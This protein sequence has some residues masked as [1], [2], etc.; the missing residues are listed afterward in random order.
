MYPNIQGSSQ[1]PGGSENRAW[2]PHNSNGSESYQRAVPVKNPVSSIWELSTAWCEAQVVAI[3]TS[4]VTA[5]ISRI[6]LAPS[7]QEILAISASSLH[8]EV[9]QMGLTGE[10]GSCVCTLTSKRLP[11]EAY[12]RW[13]TPQ[14]RVFSVPGQP[15]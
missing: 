12:T 15:E 9:S 8:V 10:L 1:F 6:P 7:P 4:T 13:G 5:F 2:R 14:G 3:R 11:V